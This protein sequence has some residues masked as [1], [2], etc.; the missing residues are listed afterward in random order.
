MPS[1]SKQRNERGATIVEFAVV[2]PLIIVLVMGIAEFSLAFKDWLTISH[3]SREGARAGATGANDITAD[4]QVLKAIEEAISG[5]DLQSIDNV[6]VSN[7]DSPFESTTY[8]YTGLLPCAWA[9]CPD[10][11]AGAPPLYAPPYAEPNYVPEDRD[12]TAP[13]PGRIKV[14]ITL[15]HEWFTGLFTNT[16]TWTAD[17]IMRLEPRVFS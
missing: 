4:I 3:A 6:V 14:S 7:P 5:G 17:T 13:I 2:F 9:P 15:T 12:V 1:N 11:Y 16:S 10:P 8:T